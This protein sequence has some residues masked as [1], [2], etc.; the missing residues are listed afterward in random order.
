MSEENDKKLY[1]HYKSVIDGSF[2]T[3]NTVSNELRVS[4]AKRHLAQLLKV[5]AKRKDPDFEEPKPEEPVKEETKSK[6]KR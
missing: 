4:D 2:S 6:R 3:G 1:S 5:R